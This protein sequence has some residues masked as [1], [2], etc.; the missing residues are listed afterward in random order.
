MSHLSDPCPVC[1]LPVRSGGTALPSAAHPREGCSGSPEP[2]KLSASSRFPSQKTH[3]CPLQAGRPPAGQRG[4][5]PRSPGGAIIHA[6][7]V[8][9]TGK[10]EGSESLQSAK[11]ICLPETT[12]VSQY[13]KPKLRPRPRGRAGAPRGERSGAV[14]G[15]GNPAYL[16]RRTTCWLEGEHRAAETCGSRA[17]PA[18]KGEA[19][20]PAPRE[21]ASRPR[22]ARREPAAPSNLNFIEGRGGPAE[23]R[24]S[25]PLPLTL[26]RAGPPAS[27]GLPLGLLPAPGRPG[28]PAMPPPPPPVTRAAFGPRGG[29]A[30]PSR[31]A[32][33][34][35]PRRTHLGVPAR[36]GA[37]PGGR[38]RGRSGGACAREW[39]GARGLHARAL[40][41][42]V[43]VRGRV[44]AGNPPV[45]RLT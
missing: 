11:A 28:R 45:A 41:R 15:A 44:G 30:P 42:R 16:W 38:G 13:G 4:F 21:A 5:A 14:R 9:N 23:R 29:P 26:P 19:P 6:S 10:E 34:P 2:A 22:A 24:L 3:G 36:R 20:T 39:G 37:G 43:A 12:S 7:P 17:R 31:R 32:S 40:R 1:E 25:P 18:A 33:G 8:R 27:A 35:R